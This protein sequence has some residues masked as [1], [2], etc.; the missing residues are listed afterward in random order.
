MLQSTLFPLSHIATDVS[1]SLG[2]W[3]VVATAAGFCCALVLE[4]HYVK[5]RGFR[6]RRLLAVIVAV[7]VAAIVAPTPGFAQSTVGPMGLPDLISD[8]PLIWVERDLDDIDGEVIRTL[9]FDGFLHNIGSGALDLAGNPQVEGGIKQRVFDGEKWEDVGEPLVRF[10]TN[11]GHNHFH[12]INAAEYSLWNESQTEQVEIGAKIGFCLLDTFQV[13]KGVE[14]QYLLDEVNYCNADEPD[15]TELS[16]GISPGWVDVYEASITLQ[17]IDV[18]AT[19]PGRYWVGAVIDPNNEIVE[20]NED[21]N[22][23]VFSQN[24]FA[25][26]GY[27]AREL[28]VQTTSQIELKSRVYGTAG[29]LAYV[30]VD[31]PEHGQ[32]SVP[33]GADVMDP[34]LAYAADDGYSGTDSFSYYAHDISSAFPYE[35]EVV[36]VQIETDGSASGPSGPADGADV[37]GVTVSAPSPEISAT[38]YET[39]SFQMEI[40]DSDDLDVEWF[41]RDLPTGLMIDRDTGVVSGELVM[42]GDTSTTIVAQVAGQPVEAAIEWTVQDTSPASLRALNDFSTVL[43]RRDLVLGVGTAENTYEGSGLPDGVVLTEGQPS[44]LGVPTQAGEFDVTVNELLDGEIV[45]TVQFTMTVRPAAKPE[46][47]L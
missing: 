3:L 43:G 27:V 45:D 12:L 42:P 23:L 25:V 26:S 47:V 11:D 44:I 31:A 33:I 2:Q 38:R 34:V 30:I 24:K 17:W 14:A 40:A 36:T 8:P 9:S 15:S 46:F 10:E 32:L 19:A 16:M 28:P 41:A 29:P 37:D 7:A 22:G 13:E 1:W 4:H 39:V 35:A 5:H 20:S 6:F 18:S 21:N